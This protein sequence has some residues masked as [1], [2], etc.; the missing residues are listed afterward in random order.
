MFCEAEGLEFDFWSITVFGEGEGQSTVV[1]KETSRNSEIQGLPS[2]YS[3]SFL[4]NMM[5]IMVT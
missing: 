4:N 5:Q 1:L 2:L 3:P